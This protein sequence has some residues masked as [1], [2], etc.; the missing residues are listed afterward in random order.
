MIFIYESLRDVGHSLAYKDVLAQGFP[1][2]LGL[3]W[4]NCNSFNHTPNTL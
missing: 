4:L 1:L 2:P 3:V